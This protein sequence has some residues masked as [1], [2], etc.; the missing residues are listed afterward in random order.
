MVRMVCR[1]CGRHT[2]TG[3]LSCWNDPRFSCE[4]C[5]E[6]LFYGQ[7]ACWMG[8]F[9][10]QRCC[11]H[12]SN[13][14]IWIPENG[15]SRPYIRH[16]QH[17]VNTFYNTNVS[18]PDL[19]LQ[20]STFMRQ[21]FDV[22]GDCPPAACMIMILKMEES[23]HLDRTEGQWPAIQAFYKRNYPHKSNREWRKEWDGWPINKAMWRAREL[24]N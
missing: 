17:V 18:L 10:Y 13:M 15:C 19:P 14:N 6:P 2:N 12:P 16:F 23:V 5:C 24:R 9:T 20:Y 11:P 8:P 1:K 3:D 21:F 4:A 22:E 7:D